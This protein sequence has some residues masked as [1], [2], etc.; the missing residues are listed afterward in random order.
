MSATLGIIG[1]PIGHSIPPM[2]R[3]AALDQYFDWE[4]G[5]YANPDADTTQ[6]I[7]KINDE[8]LAGHREIY[9]I[10]M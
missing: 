5:V 9:E 6:L 7:N 10:I 8:T 2:F 4:R 3:Q 1:F